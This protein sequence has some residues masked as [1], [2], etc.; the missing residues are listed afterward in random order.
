MSSV[1][2]G[3]LL[4][5]IAYSKL[6]IISITKLFTLLLGYGRYG[7][8]EMLVTMVIK[9]ELVNDSKTLSCQ[10]NNKVFQMNRRHL[11]NLNYSNAKMVEVSFQFN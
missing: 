6:Q 4:L 9:P 2:I 1:S 3:T 11:Q 7:Q 8:E 5:V 10:A